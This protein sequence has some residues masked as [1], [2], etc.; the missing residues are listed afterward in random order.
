MSDTDRD[1]IDRY[2]DWKSQIRS[3]LEAFEGHGPPSIDELWNVA[4]YEAEGVSGWIDEMPPT[5][6]EIQ[7]AKGD[8]LKALV[9]L[10]MAEER[11]NENRSVGPDTDQ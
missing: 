7:T 2:T 3:E 8:L 10:E 6:Q 9:A 4:G 11:L 1:G 5:Q